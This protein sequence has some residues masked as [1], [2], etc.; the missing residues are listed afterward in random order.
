MVSNV[1]KGFFIIIPLLFLNILFLFAIPEPY[2][3][4]I[5]PGFGNIPKSSESFEFSKEKVK[6][7][8]SN[9]DSIE[10]DKK[11]FFATI[12]PVFI[13]NVFKTIQAKRTSTSI[14]NGT[15]RMGPYQCQIAVSFYSSQDQS[16]ELK[17]W[18]LKRIYATT[19]MIKPSKVL[20]A[21]D[22]YQYFTR[23]NEMIKKDTKEIF[24]IY[25]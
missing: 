18:F 14:K 16:A 3:A 17:A 15:F 13:E 5:L 24:E 4:I 6:I 7:Y 25:L 21:S 10:L 1:R 2:P 11:M 19:G 9:G 20:I 12:P 22:V 23:T 8:D